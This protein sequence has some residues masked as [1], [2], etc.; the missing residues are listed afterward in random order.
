[1]AVS[2]KDPLLVGG[3]LHFVETQENRMK[4]SMSLLPVTELGVLRSSECS[5]V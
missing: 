1:M 3:L 2:S 4:A 5:W